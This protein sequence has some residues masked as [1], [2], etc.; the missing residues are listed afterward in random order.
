MIPRRL[1]IPF[2][3]FGVGIMY[4]YNPLLKYYSFMKRTYYAVFPNNVQYGFTDG[5]YDQYLYEKYIDK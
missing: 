5:E 1:F 3:L 4:T 2:I